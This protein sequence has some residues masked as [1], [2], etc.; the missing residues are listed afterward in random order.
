MVDALY[1]KLLRRYEN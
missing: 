1:C